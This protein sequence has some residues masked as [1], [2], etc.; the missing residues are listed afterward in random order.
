M[1]LGG[2]GTGVGNS[3]TSGASV[4]GGGVV[5]IYYLRLSL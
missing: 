4:Y 5:I 3:S 2:V 1:M